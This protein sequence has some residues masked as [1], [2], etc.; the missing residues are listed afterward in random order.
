M[1]TERQEE[2]AALHALGLLEGAER[3]AFEAEL[4]RNPGLRALVD[5]LAAAGSELAAA[6]PPA[7]PPDSL[8]S[9]V[10]AALDDNPAAARPA[11]PFPLV[12]HLPW[13]AAAVLA[14][15]AAVLALQNLSLR[16]ANDS[17]RTQQRLAQIAYETAQNQLTE[18]SLLAERLLN[19]LGARLKRSEDLARLKVSALASLAGNTPEARAIAVWDPEQQAGLL[20][21]EKL[22]AIAEHQDYQIW[23]IDPARQDPVSAGVFHVAEVGSVALPFWPDRPVTKAAAFAVSLEK[24]GGVPK[25]EGP[26][27]LLGNLD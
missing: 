26:I 16:S 2:L 17:L 12:R 6:A 25:A 8:K 21:F 11:A 13:A 4:A 10:M 20:T 5:S 9:R 23:V 24:K 15:I 27:L 22:P 18:R 19:E 7:A 1:I 14:L 3:R